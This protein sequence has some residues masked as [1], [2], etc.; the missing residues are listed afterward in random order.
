MKVHFR[1]TGGLLSVAR[2]DLRRPH[3]YAAERVG[4]VLCGAAWMGR[5]IVLLARDYAPV[6]DEDYI[7]DST[8]GAMM[9]PSAIRKAMQA[10]YATRSALLHV[11]MHDHKGW[12]DFSSVDIRETARFVPSF[13][14]VAPHLPHGALLLSRD[15]GRGRVWLGP[16]DCAHELFS[17]TWP[18]RPKRGFWQ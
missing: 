13:F 6:A 17:F 18:G 7:R 8:V 2:D 10:A 4:F 9:G 5:D 3:A 12:P 14:N 16:D 11:H 1:T 15:H